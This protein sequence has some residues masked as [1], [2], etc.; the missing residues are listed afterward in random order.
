MTS[1]DAL[2]STCSLPRISPSPHKRTNSVA[3]DVT[4]TPILQVKKTYNRA[5]HNLKRS[6]PFRL[7]LRTIIG[8]YGYSLHRLT[9]RYSPIQKN[10]R[11]IQLPIKPLA[12]LS[13]IHLDSIQR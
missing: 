5:K 6:C 10:R 7:R 12:V 8:G 1:R 3:A 2:I 11:Q 13:G 9:V 4:I